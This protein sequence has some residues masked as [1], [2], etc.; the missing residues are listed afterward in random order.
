MRAGMKRPFLLLLALV[1]G[2]LLPACGARSSLTEPGG[3]DACGFWNV[4]DGAV[5]TLHHASLDFAVLDDGSVVVPME[6]S[7]VGADSDAFPTVTRQWVR[8]LH[9]DGAIA[10]EVEGE[11][12][13]LGFSAA[14]RDGAGGIYVAGAVGPGAPS[15][16]GAAVPCAGEGTCAFVAK[17]T[18]MGEPTW[19]KVFPSNDV[20]AAVNHLAVMDDGRITLEGAFDGTLDLGCG[21]VSGTADGLWANLFVARLSPS[22]ECLWSRALVSPQ[23]FS[24]F[25]DMAVGDAGDVALVLHLTAEGPP[26]SS[27]DFGGGPVPS[28]SSVDYGHPLAVAKYAPDGAF[29]F[30]KV[31]TSGFCQSV[32]KVA[33]TGAGEVLLSAAY[34]GPID[35]GGGPRGSADDTRQFVTKLGATGEELWTRDIAS[36]KYGGG[37]VFAIAIEPGDGFF[38]AGQGRVGMSILGEPVPEET[39]FA[40]AFDAGGQPI[41]VQTFPFSG[42]GLDLGLSA[43]A[44]SSLVLVGQFDRV[45]D[46]D[47]GP[48][49]GPEKALVARICP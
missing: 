18:P 11:P 46:F 42:Q 44:P 17:L 29:V 3:S 28:S 19:V 15:V 20:R 26:G 9:P 34:T 6:E 7:I 13:K 8:K 2:W 36:G 40:A 32:P 30:A 21:P 4:Y 10:W 33:V 22:G 45:H 31:A 39:L 12:E 47:D 25:T 35:L 27:I 5:G 16:L 43:S 49:W 24:G 41:D 38:L 23:L 48:W 1:S 14:A 37:E